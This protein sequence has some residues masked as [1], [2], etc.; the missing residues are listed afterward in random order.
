M[1]LSAITSRYEACVVDLW[2]VVHDG[3]T[4]YPHARETLLA[5]K[6][7]GL[8]IILL[9]N[10]PRRASKVRAVLQGLGIEDG[11]YDALLTSGEVAYEALKANPRWLGTRY[12][13]LGPGKD[14][15]ILAGLAGYEEVQNPADADFILNTGFEYD[16][17]PESEIVPTLE[18]LTAHRLP[19]LCVNPDREVVKLDGTQMLCAGVVAEKY[20]E[21]RGEVHFIGKPHPRV[22]ESAI[23]QA[24]NIDPARILAIGDTPHTDILGGLNAGMDAWLITGGVLRI[25]YPEG[26]PEAEAMALCQTQIGHAPT[27]V[28]G[29]FRLAP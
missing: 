26:L 11:L 17:Q 22:Y 23:A 5:L 3:T 20:L 6:Q 2:G 19:L 8:K 27:Y 28:S 10:A 25:L 15:D 4:L 9:S 1:Q 13:Y 21:A 16:F 24:G 7:A 29:L 18:K 12:Y 14:E